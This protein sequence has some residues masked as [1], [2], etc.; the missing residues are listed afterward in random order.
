[1][2]ARHARVALLEFGGHTEIQYSQLRFLK[3]SGCEVLLCGGEASVEFMSR[4][5]GDSPLYPIPRG[6]GLAAKLRIVRELHRR[7]RD[8]DTDTVVISSYNGEMVKLFMLLKPRDLR[9]FGIVHG[10]EKLNSS[11]WVRMLTKRVRGY[12]VLNDHL[13]QYC[14]P[15]MGTVRPLY[16]IFYP[17]YPRRDIAKEDGA[18]HVCVPGQLEYKRRNYLSLLEELSDDL[19]PGIRFVLLGSSRH[20]SGDGAD[21][22]RRIPAEHRYRFVLFE[23][24]VEEELFHSHVA[25]SDL[26]MPL[27][28]GRTRYHN[29]AISGTFNLSFGYR[30]PML[31]EDEF[32][33]IDDLKTNA[34]SY[35]PGTLVD[36]L[37]ALC[38]DRAPIA[39]KTKVMEDNPKFSFEYQRS[40]YIDAI[41]ER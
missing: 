20:A 4:H 25:A 23:S 10:T 16:T 30:I 29:E 8:E 39:G 7:L 2:Q 24:F 17:P 19:H 35:A 40:A 1:M 41:F 11:A 33:A 5:A 32:M 6:Y 36:T 27:L 15:R 9:V 3:E 22:I 31:V 13:L 37:N 21:F 14:L 12:F 18:L 28:G 26:I 38:D 34:L